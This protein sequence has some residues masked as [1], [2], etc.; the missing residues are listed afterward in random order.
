MDL[1]QNKT[2]NMTKIEWI[3][4]MDND[5][6]Y[7]LINENFETFPEEIKLDGPRTILN[8]DV[9]EEIAD[10]EITEYGLGY[11]NNKITV[12]RTESSHTSVTYRSEMEL[13][14]IREKKDITIMEMSDED[15]IEA[16]KQDPSD[17]FDELYDGEVV[18]DK[19]KDMGSYDEV[20]VD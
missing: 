4:Q 8:R 1:K 9:A 13:C 2:N 18:Y 19:R 14:E 6:L 17:Y 3:K 10:D 11:S 12:D 7:D 15:L 20:T 5:E 16:I